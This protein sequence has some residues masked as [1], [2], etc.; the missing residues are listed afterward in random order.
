ME[1]KYFVHWWVL[2]LHIHTDGH[3]AMG[4]SGKAAN[5]T[6]FSHTDTNVCGLEAI[7]WVPGHACTALA[8]PN[9]LPKVRRA[10]GLHA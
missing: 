1:G 8:R 3:S 6:T 4:L 10:N 9:E 7:V 2:C 5:P